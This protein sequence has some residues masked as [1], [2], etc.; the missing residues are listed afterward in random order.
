M[1]TLAAAR[2]D[3]AEGIETLL[4]ILQELDV[5]EIID[6]FI[7]PSVAEQVPLS[8]VAEKLAERLGTSTVKVTTAV[9]G[10]AVYRSL[11][12][13]KRENGLGGLA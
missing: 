5:I 7:I 2:P 10:A 3:Q 1:A 13:Y 8:T 9:D 11:L 4:D 6:G 12:R